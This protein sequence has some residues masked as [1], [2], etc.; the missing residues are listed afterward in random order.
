MSS[1]FLAEIR[2][3]G[4]NFAIIGWALCNG[5]ILPIS[6]NTA[7]FSLLGTNFGGNGTSNF[8]L[9]NLQA[10]VPMGMG[11]GPGLTPRVIGETGGA[12]SVTLTQN[13]MAAH[14]HPAKC[15]TAD[16]AQAS[17]IGGLWAEVK[18]GRNPHNYYHN[19]SDG[20]QMNVGA[21]SPSGGN[22]PHNNLQPYLTVTFLI[23]LQGIY[24]V[25][26]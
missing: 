24:P 13:Q 15:D 1:P 10:S 11:N 25:R 22:A 20:T 26:N 8:G 7:L 9:P 19:S 18:V 14:N 12:N 21:L 6:Q 3:F 17:P 2:M 5:Q 4:G 16:G 23:A